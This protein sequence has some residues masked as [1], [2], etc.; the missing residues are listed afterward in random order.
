MTVEELV[1]FAEGLSRIAAAGGGPKALAAHLAG[2]IDAAVLV[3]DAEWHHL[4]LAG[5]GSRSIPPSTRE[6]LHA[7]RRNQEGL[8]AINPPGGPAGSALKVRA[9]DAQVGWLAV[10]PNGKP[11]AGFEPA[12]RLTAS[13]IAV[14]LARELGGT[15][16]RRRSFWERLISRSYDDVAEARDDAA[17]RGITLASGYVG[18]AVEAEGLD[19]S[20]A[21]VK[22]NEIRR[23]CLDALRTGHGDIVVLERGGGFVFLCPAPLEVDAANAR[24]AATMIPK[25]I[26]KQHLGASVVGGVGRHVDVLHTYRTVEEARESLIIARR[27]YG[28]ARIIPYEELGMY[29]LLLRGA[30]KEELAAFGERILEP[31]RAYDEKHQTELLRTL[32]LYFDV[33]QN[34]KTAAE[35]LS[36]HR[37][38]VFYRLR[39]INEIAGVEMDNPHDQLTLRTAMALHALNFER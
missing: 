20:A 4:A 1:V 12:L 11:I 31:L 7:T 22:N 18:V 39:Q 2:Q 17:S 27:M 23:L 28:G 37:H 3:E 25:A 16:G 19:E 15:K 26:A 5:S 34:V 9:G 14:E 30:S 6:L 21:A 24:T 36:V 32:Q 29:P 10:F 35:K 33:G 38:T 13:A 8:I